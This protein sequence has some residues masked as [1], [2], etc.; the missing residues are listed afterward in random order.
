MFARSKISWPILID[1]LYFWSKTDDQNDWFE[2]NKRWRWCMVYYYQSLKLN[3][4]V[5]WFKKSNYVD[6]LYPD[7][8]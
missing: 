2:K 8:D 5:L 7:Q 6:V 1:P 3:L 4:K